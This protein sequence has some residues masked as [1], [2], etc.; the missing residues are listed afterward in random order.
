MLYATSWMHTF[1]LLHTYTTCQVKPWQINV[2][3][4][5]RMYYVM[6][7]YVCRM[8]PLII[9]SLLDA[10]IFRGILVFPCDFI[11]KCIHLQHDLH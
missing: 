2:Y 4:R 8:F 1:L 11:L 7:H 10:M 3:M 9:C 5:I 6:K